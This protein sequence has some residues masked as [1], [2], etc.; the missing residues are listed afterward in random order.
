MYN[1]VEFSIVVL[2]NLTNPC[3][4]S[5]KVI[6]LSYMYSNVFPELTPSIPCVP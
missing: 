4:G 5:E 3:P 1:A 2:L 6:E